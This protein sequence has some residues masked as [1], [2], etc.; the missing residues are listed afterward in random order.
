MTVSPMENVRVED[1]ADLSWYA[2][3]TFDNA[4]NSVDVYSWN[5]SI[6]GAEG[7]LYEGETFHLRV[8]ST[9]CAPRCWLTA[10][11]QFR[12]PNSYPMESPEVRALFPL[13]L[14]Y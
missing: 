12:F 10:C 14:V 6:N 13:L 7:T 1:A 4:A 5:I 8:R 11:A 2:R 9:L 3:A